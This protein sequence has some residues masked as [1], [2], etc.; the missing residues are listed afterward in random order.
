MKEK[1]EKIP[2]LKNL[3]LFLDS[4]KL[5]KYPGFSI[6]DLIEIYFSGIIK[7]VFSARAGSVSFSFF[8]ALFPFLL[9]ILNRR[10]STVRFETFKC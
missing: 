6:Y 2:I 7:G 10:I 5:P 3:I 9:F 1:A 8:M 4:I